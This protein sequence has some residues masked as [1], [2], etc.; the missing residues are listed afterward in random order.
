MTG[1]VSIR[2]KLFDGEL[3]SNIVEVQVDLANVNDPP[4]PV[5]PYNEGLT[6][7]TLEDTTLS[8]PLTAVDVDSVDIAVTV[9]A[10]PTKGILRHISTGTV[11]RSTYTFPGRDYACEFIPVPG[12]ASSPADAVYTTFSLSASDGNLNSPWRQVRIVVT[13][14]NDAPT[15]TAPTHFEVSINK[16]TVIAMSVADTDAGSGTVLATITSTYG[17]LAL[18]SVPAGVT[19]VSSNLDHTLSIMGHIEHVNEAMKFVT[20]SRTDLG[21][22]DVIVTI[23]DQ[24]NSGNSLAHPAMT[25][26]SQGGESATQT[27]RV[28]ATSDNAMTI[29]LAVAG[30]GIALI[31]AAVGLY[32]LARRGA[33]RDTGWTEEEPFLC[34][35]GVQNNAIYEANKYANQENP[36]YQS[37]QN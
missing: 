32:K 12:D 29:T 21:E 31:L 23:N 2:V 4:E 24:G 20:Y 5:D 36:L 3:W 16:A 27:I 33:A 6:Y 10:P 1:I 26:A 28:R 30:G 37:P 8:L 19:S 22:E 9:L 14:I 18:S 34:E 35:D 15:L 13:P 7:T 25:S 17:T 11:I